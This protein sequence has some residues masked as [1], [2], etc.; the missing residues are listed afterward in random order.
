MT[1]YGKKCK[2]NALRVWVNSVGISLSKFG[3][4]QNKRYESG[5]Y[6]LRYIPDILSLKI[7]KKL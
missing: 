2:K 4:V 7:L 3:S 1:N 5:P 6:F